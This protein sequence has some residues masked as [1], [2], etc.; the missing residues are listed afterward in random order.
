M[1]N[2]SGAAFDGNGSVRWEVH[3]SEDAEHDH[4]GNQWKCVDVARE[5]RPRG[6]RNAGV[7][8]FGRGDFTITLKVP[9]AGSERSAFL[10][11]FANG[12]VRGDVVVISLRIAKVQ[13]QVEIQWDGSDP[14]EDAEKKRGE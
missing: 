8:R 1:A 5:D 6:R 3:T 9:E 4:Q 12:A 7:D 13:N 11:Q 10:R 2:G 14:T